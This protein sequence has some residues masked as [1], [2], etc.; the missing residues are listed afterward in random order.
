MS[1]SL[2][3]CPRSQTGC[4]PSRSFILAVRFLS[5]PG[6][7]GGR[8]PSTSLTPAPAPPP[9]TAAPA[10]AAATAATPAPA[11]AAAASTAAAAAA[12]LPASAATAAAARAAF[13]TSPPTVAR[14]AS[15]RTATLSLAGAL[16]VLLFLFVF[17]VFLV[18]LVF[19]LVLLRQT[20]KTQRYGRGRPLSAGWGGGPSFSVTYSCTAPEP[21]ADSTLLMRE[22]WSWIRL[23]FMSTRSA[24]ALPVL[25]PWASGKRGG[26]LGWL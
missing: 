2:R 13:A 15:G 16:P 25:P 26:W 21:P 12:G 17:F 3:G 20:R 23:F 1:D 14:T 18:L 24:N 22:G 7:T 6:T 19:V 8:T 11:A 9:T 5:G 10:A 4:H